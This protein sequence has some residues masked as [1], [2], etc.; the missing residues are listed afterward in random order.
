MRVVLDTSVYVAGILNPNG[1]SGELLRLWREEAM[2]EVIASPRLFNELLETLCKPKL[3]GRFEPNDPE[4]AIQSF[5]QTAELW[6]DTPNP[7]SATR[8]VNDDFLVSLTLS[9]AAEAL[10]T[11]DNDLLVLTRLEHADGSLI[12]VVRPGDLLAWL[13]H[14]GLR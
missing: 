7:P 13:R 2:F 5:R 8:D 12:P 10:V 9:S 1:G 14:S 11:L 6:S 3:Q 4:S